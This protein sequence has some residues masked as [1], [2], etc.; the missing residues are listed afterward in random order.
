[1][2]LFPRQSSPLAASNPDARFLVLVV[3]SRA[4]ADKVHVDVENA[5]GSVVRLRRD[6][7]ADFVQI[8]HVRFAD[9]ECRVVE[10]VA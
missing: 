1:M 9:R 6:D 5:L 3:R 2:A 4:G 7:G 8:D 10:R